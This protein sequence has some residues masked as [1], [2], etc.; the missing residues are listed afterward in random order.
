M[1]KNRVITMSIFIALIFCSILSRIQAQAVYA[2]CPTQVITDHYIVVP[3]TVGNKTWFEANEYCI[4]EFNTGLATYNESNVNEEMEMIAITFGRIYWIGVFESNFTQIWLD[5]NGLYTNC[6][7]CNM[8]CGVM[9]PFDGPTIMTLPCNS[10]ERFICNRPIGLT[11]EAFSATQGSGFYAAEQYCQ[12]IGGHLASVHD[13][14]TNNFMGDYFRQNG[15]VY[16]W[17]GLNYQ[18]N[19]TDG[20][21]FDY[22]P[23]FLNAPTNSPEC[24]AMDAFFPPYDYRWFAVP[25]TNPYDFICNAIPRRTLL[26]RTLLDLSNETFISMKLS[27]NVQNILPDPS[28][29]LKEPNVNSLSIP[30]QISLMENNLKFTDISHYEPQKNRRRILEDENVINAAEC[31]LNKYLDGIDNFI[32][33]S[34]SNSFDCLTINNINEIII[35]CVF[36]TNDSVVYDWDLQDVYVEINQCSLMTM[37]AYLTNNNSIIVESNQVT[38]L[39]YF[40][41]VFNE[42]ISLKP[43]TEY[44]VIVNITEKGNCNENIT[45]TNMKINTIS[46]PSSCELG[47]KLAQSPEIRFGLGALCK[48]NLTTA[49]IEKLEQQ[50]F[51]Q[52]SSQHMISAET[53]AMLRNYSYGSTPTPTIRRR[54]Q[55]TCTYKKING[56]TISTCPPAGGGEPSL[57]PVL[58]ATIPKVENRQNRPMPNQRTVLTFSDGV[59]VAFYAHFPSAIDPCLAYDDDTRRVFAVG[60]QDNNGNAVDT[61]E[62]LQI[63]TLQNGTVLTEY[64]LKLDRPR[65]SCMCYFHKTTTGK[66]YI[67]AINGMNKI[68]DLDDSSLWFRDMVLIQIIN[69]QGNTIVLENALKFNVIDMT[70]FIYSEQLYL[71]GGRDHENA[72]PYIQAINLQ[73]VF[74]GTIQNTS[75]LKFEERIQPLQQNRVIPFVDFIEINGETCIMAM[76]GQDFNS[77]TQNGFI[78]TDVPLSGL[79]FYCN[80]VLVSFFNT[81]KRRLQQTIQKIQ[82]TKYD[83]QNR[84]KVDNFKVISNDKNDKIYLT[85]YDFVNNNDVF[86]E[87]E[88]DFKISFN[89]IQDALIA[90]N[91]LNNT[92]DTYYQTLANISLAES[93]KMFFGWNFGFGTIDILR[94]D[95]SKNF[96]ATL[97]PTTSPTN[98]TVSPTQSPSIRTDPPSPAPKNE[99]YI[100]VFQPLKNWKDAQTF[101]ENTY[102]TDLATVSTK[103]DIESILSLI[104][105]AT[106]PNNSSLWIGL[107][108]NDMVQWY[109]WMDKLNCPIDRTTP[110]TQYYYG[111]CA[112]GKLWFSGKPR[113]SPDKDGNTC[114][115]L[116]TM[117]KLIDDSKRCDILMSF[118]CNTLDKQNQSMATLPRNEIGIANK[119][120]S[121]CNFDEEL[122]YNNGDI[123]LK[124]TMDL[125]NKYGMQHNKL[126]ERRRLSLPNLPNAIV[127]PINFHI[128]VPPST[129]EFFYEP[130]YERIISQIN[131]LNNA[132]M[133]LNDD[134][135]KTGMF[136]DDV[137]SFNIRFS[138][139]KIIRICSDQ[140]ILTPNA[141]KFTASGGSDQ[142]DSNYVLNIW[143]CNLNTA[144][145]ATPPGSAKNVDGFVLD[146][147]SLG[148]VNDYYKSN[149]EPYYHS[150]PH[151][152]TAVHEIGHWLN[153]RHIWGDGGCDHDDFV[154]DT[155]IDDSYTDGCPIINDTSASSCGT[156]DMFMN[157]MDYSTCRNMFTKGQVSRG[158]DLFLPGGAR[159]RLID[160]HF[161]PTNTQFV[162]YF[163]FI[164]HKKCSIDDKL[165]DLNFNM[166][167]KSDEYKFYLCIHYT[168]NPYVDVIT[169]LK[170]TESSCPSSEWTFF[171]TNL[172]YDGT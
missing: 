90:F 138:L 21:A 159:E 34:G 20:S 82:F 67:M 53:Q 117:Q 14:E 57:Y 104:N 19:W 64:N 139:N 40:E 60:G 59:T 76:G 80:E 48:E 171:D 119:Y 99:D 87:F 167:A 168:N 137:G 62:V 49:I 154:N 114:V 111:S 169:N 32:F 47:K 50:L 8:D 71:F 106:V 4:S 141:A 103:E 131:V 44:N 61:I 136:S 132:F 5:K 89:N 151:G 147:H 55:T 72:V 112:P 81:T 134:I 68:S 166:G 127:I 162:D 161:N 135:T 96:T 133:A 24:S 78:P 52:H 98:I 3:E 46:K 165:I 158:L 17:I 155:S 18:T 128:I 10:S 92:D 38:N 122:K 45:V 36:I 145:S 1:E 56:I 79:Q 160:Y 152:T 164:Q 153:L 7:N 85:E 121:E 91:F 43:N 2:T 163:Y 83:L 63:D 74:D 126:L 100:Y 25:C 93:K 105:T 70:P 157:F 16:A 120:I 31:P 23:G 94:T 86:Y 13:V 146:M 107:Y 156:H 95:V 101:C 143:V 149:T 140:E 29:I 12:S 97:M 41:F 69:F 144:G 58:I 124:M 15:I 108:A 28:F 123:E 26:E 116:E 125:I 109:D 150:R 54:M 42:S 30:L 88:V 22:N 75:T 129:V 170:I 66:E 37:K 65:F 110:F 172:N 73:Q 142:I 115:F 11:Y 113:C 148:D 130:G 51:Q 9:D 77:R 118:A 33:A 39:T 6:L 27:V 102:N 84:V 35:K